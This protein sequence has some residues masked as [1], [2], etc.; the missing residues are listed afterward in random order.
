M[1]TLLL[2]L[3]LT[4]REGYSPQYAVEYPTEAA[5]IAAANKGT[6]AYGRAGPPVGHIKAVCVPKLLYKEGK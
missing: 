4:G 3:I 6:E 1:K 2:V 5:C